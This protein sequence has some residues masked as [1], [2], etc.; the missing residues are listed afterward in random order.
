MA[1]GARFWSYRTAAAIKWIIVL[2]TI[3]PMCGLGK[4]PTQSF[5]V[6]AMIH[7]TDELT[8]DLDQDIDDIVALLAERWPECFAVLENRRRP[9]KVGIHKDI[10][11][12]LG[13]TVSSEQLSRALVCYCSVPEYQ[14]RLKDKAARI[15]LD[16]RQAGVVTA[17]EAASSWCQGTSWP[18]AVSRLQDLAHRLGLDWHWLGA[19]RACRLEEHQLT[20]ADGCRSHRQWWRCGSAGRKSWRL[21]LN[22]SGK[23]KVAGGASFW[24]W[25]L[26][27]T[28]C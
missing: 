21:R 13:T 23:K 18:A 28:S 26:I 14:S 6:I 12:A 10:Q 5:G 17:P 7:F 4:K 27:C 3:L 1:P 25:L 2:G 24:I 22:R 8:M 19:T 15:D 9:L 11:A 20:G 16:G